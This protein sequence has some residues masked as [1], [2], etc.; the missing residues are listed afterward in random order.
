MRRGWGHACVVRAGQAC[1]TGGLFAL[2]G[3]ARPDEASSQAE[4]DLGAALTATC[5][6]SYATTGVCPGPGRLG[7]F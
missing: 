4:L 3:H 1:F 2:G 5:R 6:A 7:L